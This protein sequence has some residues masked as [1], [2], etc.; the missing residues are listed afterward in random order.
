MRRPSGLKVKPWRRHAMDSDRRHLSPRLRVPEPDAAFAD[1]R[2]EGPPIGAILRA[3]GHFDLARDRQD[4]PVG[5]EVPE[6]EAAAPGDR[7]E[8]A[9][10]RAESRAEDLARL[11][12]EARAEPAGGGVPEPHRLVLAGRGDG[13]T[14]WAERHAGHVIVGARQ[15]EPEPAGGGLPDPDRVIRVAGD[16]LSAVRAEGHA[17]RCLIETLE[18]FAS[19]HQGPGGA[20]GVPELDRPVEAARGEGVAVGAERDPADAVGVPLE[21]AQRAARFDVPDSHD[22]IGPGRG[23]SAPVGVDGQG[24]DR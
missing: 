4:R 13:L 21:G 19:E 1:E 5:L 24:C 3:T 8:T 18:G 22:R 23:E 17:V 9:S 14:G 15:G 6:L 2:R 16:D 20:A 7:D 12:R 10:V 11:L